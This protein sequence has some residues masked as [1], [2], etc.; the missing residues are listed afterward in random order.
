VKRLYGLAERH[1]LGPESVSRFTTLLR[2]LEAP[3]APTT[4]HDPME[5]VDVHVADALSALELPDVRAA[6]LLADLGA[7]AGVPG[8]VLAAALPSTRVALVE[9]VAKKCAFIAEAA[10][11][12][13]L[14]NV[15]VVCGRAEEWTEGHGRCDVVTARALAALPVLCEYAAPLLRPRGLLVA[16]KGDVSPE[17]ARDGRAAAQVLGL[18]EPQVV[19]VEPYPGSRSRRLYL[20]RKTAPTPAGFPRRPGMATKRPL[21]ASSRT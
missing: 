10:A 12:M 5:A 16:W 18:S 14:D 17:E 4:V 13:E 3:N 15:E 21:S 9:S 11:A 19:P 7:G 20:F 1:G 6:G 8:L 2:A